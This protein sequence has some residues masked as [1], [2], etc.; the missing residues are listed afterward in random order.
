MLKRWTTLAAAVVPLML[1]AGCTPEPDPMARPD[2][3]FRELNKQLHEKGLKRLDL[4]EAS[5]KDVTSWL[6]KDLNCQVAIESAAIGF[7]AQTDPRITAR[8]GEVPADL[9][10]QVVRALLEAK[11]LTLEPAGEVDDKPRLTVGRS[12]LRE[13][14]APKSR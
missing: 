6:E 1:V 5:V 14:T 2:A 10:F 13:A 8:M 3:A 9:A 11:G 7:I 12:T 4:Q